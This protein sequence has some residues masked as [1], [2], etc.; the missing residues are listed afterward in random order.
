MKKKAAAK[1]KKAK[2]TKRKLPAALAAWTQ[3]VKSGNVKR[4]SRGRITK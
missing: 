4:D 2:S 3:K 1:P